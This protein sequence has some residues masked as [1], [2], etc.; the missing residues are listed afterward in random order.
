MNETPWIFYAEQ[1]LASCGIAI[2]DDTI[3]RQMRPLLWR[4]PARE[5]DNL[6]REQMCAAA[7]EN[8]TLYSAEIKVGD[9]GAGRKIEIDDMGIVRLVKPEETRTIPIIALSES[10]L[11][12][13]LA[14]IGVRVESIALAQA[15]EPP[16][17]PTPEEVAAQE[18]RHREF[19]AK[20]GF[21]PG[22]PPRRE[23]E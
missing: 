17:A 10:Q 19:C 2:M 16:K 12:E 23:A 9:P 13:R 6:N 5:D 18:A 20:M 4:T 1:Q 21:Y 11:A 3:A 15:E 22:H 7:L 8:G 14:W